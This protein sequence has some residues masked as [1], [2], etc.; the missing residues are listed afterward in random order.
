MSNNIELKD[1]HWLIDMIQNIDV[2]L[3]IIDLDMKV[4]VWNGFMENHSGLLARH[5]VDRKLNELFE[6]IPKA[7]LQQKINSV[8]LLKN[9]AF[10]TW[11]Q[12]PFVF[13]FKSYRP[14]TSKAAFMYQNVTFLP[15]TDITGKVT[16][17]CMIIYDVTDVALNKQ[18]FQEANKKLE[19]L[20]HTD[21]LTQLNNQGHWRECCFR[22]YK[23]HTRTQQPSS[24]I[25]L[26][27]DFFKKVNDTYG[28]P[29]GDEVIREVANCLR[30]NMRETD[31]AGRY[32]GEEFTLILVDTDLKNAQLVAERIRIAVEEYDF[33]YL[34]KLVKVTISLG[35]AQITGNIP[36]Y[37][38]WIKTA[39]LGL[40]IAKDSGR[41][42]IGIS[43]H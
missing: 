30:K 18:A 22:E 39:D 11:E 29:F 41:N 3:V 12:R 31:I 5:I 33:Y 15:L 40:Y 21:T 7:W 36:D 43:D 32:G 16:Q 6:D 35:V 9:K 27:I 28:H 2:G 20:S 34:D 25:M 38:T 37:K 23:R 13:K 14:I 1:I 42:Q 19:N 17:I 4:K 10:T 24:L 26:D 8:Y